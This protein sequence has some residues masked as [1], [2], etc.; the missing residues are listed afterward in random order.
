MRGRV[1]VP[2]KRDA[3]PYHLGRPPILSGLAAPKTPLRPPVTPACRRSYQRLLMGGPSLSVSRMALTYQ[4]SKPLFTKTGAR[5][6]ALHTSLYQEWRPPIGAP[7][8]SALRVA[9]AYRCSKT[10][11]VKN[12]ARVSALQISLYQEWR[13]P[14]GAPN[15]SLSW[16]PPIGAPDPTH[17]CT[18]TIIHVCTIAIVHACTIAMVHAC[19]MAIVYSC[20]IAKLHVL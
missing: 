12:G 6:S 3:L 7:N 18:A 10:S 14:I 9:P 17:E 1:Y 11:C 13:P 4:R 15:P 2:I 16:R 8:L 19:T 5:L 20:T